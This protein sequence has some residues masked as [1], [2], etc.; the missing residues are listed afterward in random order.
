MATDIYSLQSGG[1]L[2]RLL[3]AN[4]TADRVASWAAQADGMKDKFFSRVADETGPYRLTAT[5]RGHDVSDV[6]PGFTGKAPQGLPRHKPLMLQTNATVAF[7]GDSIA[8][9]TCDAFRRLTSSGQVQHYWSSPA[10]LE[11]AP[12]GMPTRMKRETDQMLADVIACRAAVD[13]LV[14]GGIGA[15]RLYREAHSFNDEIRY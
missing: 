8:T 6:R 10:G 4:L 13:G 2:C 12:C 11:P 1:E 7:L 9:E 3:C 15:H 5:P 14:V